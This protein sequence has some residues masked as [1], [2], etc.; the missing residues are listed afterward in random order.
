MSVRRRQALTSRASR[1]VGH[2]VAWQRQRM[3]DPGPLESLFVCVSFA[4]RAQTDSQAQRRRGRQH[5]D[6]PGQP[7]GQPAAETPGYHHQRRA[8]FPF[9]RPRWPA[10]VLGLPRH[11]LQKPDR[12]P[13]GIIKLSGPQ[14][15]AAGQRRQRLARDATLLEVKGQGGADRG[16]AAILANVVVQSQCRADQRRSPRRR[17][18]KPLLR[19]SR[20]AG[21][22]W[23]AQERG[24]TA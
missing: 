20:S 4:W 10:G 15:V 14:R 11:G 16:P 6:R 21:S 5:V 18:A 24:S 19:R 23:T 12:E 1:T 17:W 22:G 9:H 7:G 2:W 3:K 8:S 13:F